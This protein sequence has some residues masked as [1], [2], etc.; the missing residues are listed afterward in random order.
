LKAHAASVALEKLRKSISETLGRPPEISDLTDV[1]CSEVATTDDL[2]GD[3]APDSDV[4]LCLPPGGHVWDHYLYFS[5]KGCP[6]FADHLVDAELTP[7]EKSNKGVKD[8]DAVGANG[9]AGNDFTWTHWRWDGSGYHVADTATCDLCS[10]QDAPKPGPKANR[11]AYCK[12]E[13]ARRKS[14]KP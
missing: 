8:L 4:S 2:D 14:R 1:R 13:I 3:G 10:D 5:N 12:Q 11:H 6:R 7:L 9:C